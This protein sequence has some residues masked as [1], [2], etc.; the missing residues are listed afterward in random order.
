MVPS[1]TTLRVKAGAAQT[2][3][4]GRQRRLSWIILLS[5]GTVAGA[6][7]LLGLSPALFSGRSSITV[8]GSASESAPTGAIAESDREFCKRLR[9]DDAGRAFQDV[10]P[11]DGE[12]TRDARGQSVPAGTMHRLDAISKSFSGR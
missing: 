1:N 11:C 7:V 2:S 12:S 3:R 8:T 5:L 4:R 6:A 9:F 10:V